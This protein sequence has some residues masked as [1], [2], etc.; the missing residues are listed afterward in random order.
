M[1]P[2]GSLCV[3]MRVREDTGRLATPGPGGARQRSPTRL[4]DRAIASI[5]AFVSVRDSV[6][7]TQ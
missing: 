5:C 2:M 4:S 6:F 7:D 3:L 1:T